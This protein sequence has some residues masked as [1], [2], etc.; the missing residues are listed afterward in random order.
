MSVSSIFAASTALRRR[1]QASLA[2]SDKA[3]PD[4]HSSA[5]ELS[6]IGET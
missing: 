6:F 5:R 4:Y 2:G 1:P 3:T